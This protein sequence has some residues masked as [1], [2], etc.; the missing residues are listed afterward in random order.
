[1]ASQTSGS[2]IIDNSGRQQK[3]RKGA[4]KVE[5]DKGWLRL[6]FT[7]E[8]KRHAFALGIPDSALN[9]KIAEA[10][11]QQI[12]LDILSGNFDPTLE[13]YRPEKLPKKEKE[14]DSL[15]V[16]KLFSRF[17]EHKAKEVSPKTMEKYQATYRYLSEFF[18]NKPIDLLEEAT[19]E[20]FTNWQLNKGLS[21]VQV[22]RR[23]EE[24][25]ACWLWFDSTAL[26][27]WKKVAD[28]LNHYALKVHR[29]LKG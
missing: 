18:P 4:V 19:A 29:F 28:R 10:K 13:K 25:G 12:E 24:I 21:A 5:S 23:L 11:A 9:W 1:M 3:S 6:R 2:R 15:T 14:S 16:P 26:N 20:D 8:G 7:K 27:P 22:K 17:M